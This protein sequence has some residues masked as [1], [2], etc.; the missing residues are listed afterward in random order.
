M[1]NIITDFF[2]IIRIQ[3][4]HSKINENQRKPLKMLLHPKYFKHGWIGYTF[5]KV[6]AFLILYYIII[7]IVAIGTNGLDKK[8]HCGIY[9]NGTESKYPK[10]HLDDRSRYVQ[11]HT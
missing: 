2:Y 8:K 3:E 9:K 5:T 11:V 7:I 6:L 4:H 1:K 10:V